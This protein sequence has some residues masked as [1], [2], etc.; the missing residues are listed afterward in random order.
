MANTARSA[1]EAQAT[2][3]LLVPKT[4]I[5]ARTVHVTWQLHGRDVTQECVSQDDLYV[6]E[7][8]VAV[9]SFESMATPSIPS[10]SGPHFV[11][12]M[13]SPMNYLIQTWFLLTGC[14]VQGVPESV[15]VGVPTDQLVS[16]S[17]K[18]YSRRVRKSSKPTEC[19][20]LAQNHAKIV[21]KSSSRCN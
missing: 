7:N 9:Q 18:L 3:F 8:H 15:V 14:I 11:A 13:R 20:T 16:N 19:C 4:S 5:G 21:S 12:L 10:I 17:L 2:L 1:V 6:L